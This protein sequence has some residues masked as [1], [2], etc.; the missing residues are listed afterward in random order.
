MSDI[1]WTK[2]T[3][4]FTDPIEWWRTRLN[5]G[6]RPFIVAVEVAPDGRRLVSFPGLPDQVD[7]VNLPAGALWGGR[8]D[9]GEGTLSTP[10]LPPGWEVD[11]DREPTP[12]GGPWT[13]ESWEARCGSGPFAVKQYFMRLDGIPVWRW[14]PGAW[15]RVGVNET[16]RL[17]ADVTTPVG[18]LIPI[19]RVQ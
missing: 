9:M 13:A 12:T 16:G 7:V 19:R 10:V 11:P 5:L 3:P 8:I 6:E 17:Y 14:K 4:T 2:G 15:C 1:T 18:T